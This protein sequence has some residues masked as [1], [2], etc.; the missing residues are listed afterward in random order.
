[1]SWPPSP[2]SVSSPPRP[3]MTSFPSVRRPGRRD[4]A[5]RA[6]GQ[7]RLLA[8]GAVED[9][10]LAGHVLAA[11]VRGEAELA[12]VRRPCR[13]RRR[14]VRAGRQLLAAAAVRVHGPNGRAV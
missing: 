5:L 10:A 4:R 6:V 11:L 2:I 3:Q 13:A 8:G 9:V 14:A 12:P 1:M 7:C